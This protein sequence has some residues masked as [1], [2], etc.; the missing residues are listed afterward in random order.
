MARGNI[1]PLKDA[2]GILMT[3]EKPGNDE[4]P[5]EMQKRIR[6]TLAEGIAEYIDDV[7]EKTKWKIPAQSVL[8]NATGQV[9]PVKN[10]TPIEVEHN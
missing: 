4:T 5:A 2:L 3:T 8:I 1:D 6:D 10:P 9:V 7:L